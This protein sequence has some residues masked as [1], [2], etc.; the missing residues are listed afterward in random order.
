MA[1]IAVAARRPR[2][3]PSAPPSHASAR[4]SVAATSWPA[5]TASLSPPPLVP[6]AKW[7][8]RRV[9]LDA[10]HGAPDNRGNRSCYCVDEQDFT[11]RVAEHVAR[12]WR[13]HGTFQV[14]L[15]RTGQTRV[16]YY[17]RVSEARAWRAAAFIS[18]HSDVRG[19]GE[20]WAPT[21]DQHCQRS[22]GRAGFSVLWSDDAEASLRARRLRL[23]RAVARQLLSLGVT[24]YDGHNYTESYRP[25]PDTPG[26]FVDRHPADQ[27]IFVLYAP[28]MPS[29]II[30]THHAWDPD[31]AR[32]WQQLTTLD[33]FSDAL[34][35]ALFEALSA[36]H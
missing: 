6:P 19:G 13:R 27:R 2:T 9:Y 29:I 30:E 12:R 4:A 22:S 35:V 5:P 8:P 10:G 31:E 17:T 7:S 15:S 26:V 36:A 34:E 16:D 24:A 23:A 20:S 25:H 1:I 11:L 14:R 18:I 32:H 28:T 21:P 33:A 3:A